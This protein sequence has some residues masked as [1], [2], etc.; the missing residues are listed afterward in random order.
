MKISSL[1]VRREFLDKKACLEEAGRI[2]RE[3]AI[4]GMSQKQLASEIYFHALAFFFCEKTGLLPK[5]KEHADP[6][7]LND[8]GDTLLRRIVYAAAWKLSDHIGKE[9]KER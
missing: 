9:K 8:G 3:G 6:V 4:S 5:M 7:D 1:E 2:L